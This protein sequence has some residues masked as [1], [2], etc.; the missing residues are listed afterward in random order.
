MLQFTM[1]DI[2]IFVKQKEEDALPLFQVWALIRKILLSTALLFILLSLG[3][4][5]RLQASIEDLMSPPVLTQEQAEIRDALSA[6]SGENDI[7]YKYPQ[8]G[9]YRSSFIFYDIDSDG[10]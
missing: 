2:F 7:K 8:N 3:G 10:S 9:Q 6:V 1:Q 5:S 4:C